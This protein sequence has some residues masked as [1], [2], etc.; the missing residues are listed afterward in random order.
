MEPSGCG[1]RS[2][3]VPRTRIKTGP[4][5]AGKTGEWAICCSGGGIRSASYCLGALQSLQGPGANGLF[6]NVSHIL[7]VSGGSYIAASRAL[8]ARDLKGA[9]PPA[10]GPG[11]PEEQH[12]RDNTH[13]IAPNGGI[14]LVGVL[15]LL[16][17]VAVTFILVF[18]PVF[19]AAHAW[20]WLLRSQ[21]VLC[22]GS[23][24]ECGAPGPLV[25]SVTS[26]AWWWL[27][28]A[29]AAGLTLLLF[30]CWWV[31]LKPQREERQADPRQEAPRDS[32]GHPG[33]A[34]RLGRSSGRR[35][36]GR[37]AGGPSAAVLGGQAPGRA[38]QVAGL[39]P[40]VRRRPYV[41]AR[42]R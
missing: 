17:G 25:A 5:I 21:Q 13:Y 27:V 9:G 3:A 2:D 6:G 34:H 39:R 16:V 8:V 10:Y 7:S 41:D 22:P 33:D 20:G 29:A 26:P 18:A 15:S 28:P 4:G 19:A 11:T 24:Q 1:G 36:G 40:R 30:G 42:P 31:T 38:V 23:V 35:A 14:V 12:L 32:R 37:H